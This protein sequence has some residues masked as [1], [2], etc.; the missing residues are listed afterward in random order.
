MMDVIVRIIIILVTVEIKS[1]SLDWLL[2]IFK[3]WQERHLGQQRL[4]M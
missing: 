3:G 1:E 4:Q 2:L